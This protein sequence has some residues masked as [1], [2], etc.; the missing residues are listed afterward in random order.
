MQW[1]VSGPEMARIIGEFCTVLDKKE[2]VSRLHHHEDQPGDLTYNFFPNIFT[3]FGYLQS[4]VTVE[5]QETK[6]SL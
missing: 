1:M 6:N 4:V 5:I 2:T 3:V